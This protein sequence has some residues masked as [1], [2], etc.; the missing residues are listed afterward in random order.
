MQYILTQEEF[1]NLISKSKYEEKCNQV[2]NLQML[3]LKAS[4]F[5]CIHD[6]TQEDEEYCDLFYCD[7]CPLAHFKPEYDC[8]KRK[9]FSQ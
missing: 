8:G 2:K 6:R 5:K 7:Y 3:L 4:N 9:N 1:D